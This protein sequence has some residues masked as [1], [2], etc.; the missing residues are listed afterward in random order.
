MSNIDFS[1]ELITQSENARLGKIK[2]SRGD[3]DTPAFMPVG[4]LGTVKGV[5]TD[6]LLKTNSQ[7]ILGNT[8]H[9]FI[10]PGI[11]VLKKF[12]GLHKYMNN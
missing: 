3:I 8:Y 4:T 9:L 10:R 6:D 7:I 2:T 1:F 11:E 12:N 5:F